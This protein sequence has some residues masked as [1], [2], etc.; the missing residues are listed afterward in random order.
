[1]ALNIVFN[2]FFYYLQYLDKNIYLEELEFNMNNINKEDLMLYI[3]R[4][5]SNI[6]DK[7]IINLDNII[8]RKGLP[9]FEGCIETIIS[10]DIIT[11]SKKILDTKYCSFCKNIFIPT[12][13]SRNYCRTCFR[14]KTCKGKP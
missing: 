8:E 11:S 6:S 10:L 2:A 3:K 13:K 5:F 7:A 9:R 1:M 12:R 14:Q 4:A